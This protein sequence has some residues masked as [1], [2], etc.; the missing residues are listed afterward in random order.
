MVIDA[1][2][3]ERQKERQTRKEALDM[4]SMILVYDC[5]RRPGDFIKRYG[6]RFPHLADMRA[7][8]FNHPLPSRLPTR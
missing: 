6:H 4:I 2:T 8:H 1:R 5:G 7:E 3:P